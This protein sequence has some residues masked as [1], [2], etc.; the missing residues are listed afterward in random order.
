MVP[1]PEDPSHVCNY[2]PQLAFWILKEGKKHKP[3][4]GYFDGLQVDVPVIWEECMARWPRNGFGQ[5][6]DL[7][8]SL[9]SATY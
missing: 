1:L 7:G 6:T 9:C 2:V 5:P 3:L 8:S 4:R